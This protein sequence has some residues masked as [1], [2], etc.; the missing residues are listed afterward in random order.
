[1]RTADNGLVSNQQEYPLPLNEDGTLSFYWID[2]HEENNGADLFIFGKIYQNEERKY[3]SCS[4]KVNGMQ[5]ELFV[6][7]KMKGK[8]R[9]AMTTEEEKE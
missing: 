5:R 4:I 3:V 9:A 1:M 2:A 7:P 8:S 6:L